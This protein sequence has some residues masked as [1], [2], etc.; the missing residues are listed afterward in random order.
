MT[1]ATTT[2]LGLAQLAG[3]VLSED[4]VNGALTRVTQLSVEIVTACDGASLTMRDSGVPSAPAADS[5]WSRALDELQFT[6]QE[7]PCLDCLRDGSVMR[8]RDLREDSRF[9]SYGPRAAAQGALSA[10]S[11]PLA[12]DGRTVGALN[13]Y[14][15]HVDGFD[16]AAL[17]TGEVLAA[18]ASLAVQ[19]AAAYF[20]HRDLAE[21][22]R[23]AIASRA[24]IEQ[25]KGVLVAQQQC[26]PD[27]AFE[28]LVA[29]SQ[30]SNTKLR[31]V[32]ARVVRDAQGR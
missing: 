29:A 19:T 11:L 13:L 26:S 22:L 9:P 4:D 21:Q 1:D 3:I 27:A 5:A 31:E 8:V 2:A 24:V 25:A 10:L 23:E 12:A 30:R 28:L 6:E 18:H 14:S 16:R 20:S 7:G 17:A 32:A 15:R